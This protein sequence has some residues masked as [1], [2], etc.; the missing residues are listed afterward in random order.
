MKNKILNTFAEAV[1]DIPHGASIM[2]SSWGTAG[3]PFN[4]ILALQDHGARNLTYISQNIGGTHVI[5]QFPDKPGMT[6]Y[7][8]AMPYILLHSKQIKKVIVTWGRGTD[9]NPIE[10]MVNSGEVQAEI[11]PLG[12]L[13]E[14]MRIGGA[15]LQGFYTTTGVGTFYEKGKETKVIDGQKCILELPLRADFGFVR[16]YKADTLGNLVYR[17]TSRSINPLVAKASTVTIAEV[18]EIVEAGELDPEC[19]ITPGL[20]I[21]RIVKIPEGGLR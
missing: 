17:M 13:V 2:M 1:A 15:G 7:L 8:D 9:R 19:I 18:D 12:I 6:R 10:K 16:A 21:D 20:H 11:V 3:T 4:L 5:R 14:R